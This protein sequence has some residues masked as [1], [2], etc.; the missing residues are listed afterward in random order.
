MSTTRKRKAEKLAASLRVY[1]GDE[2]DDLENATGLD[3]DSGPDGDPD[4][5]HDREKAEAEEFWAG[6]KPA[7]R[8]SARV[9]A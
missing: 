8:H 3:P 2:L 9:A 5:A 7:A 6:R 1:R 4:P